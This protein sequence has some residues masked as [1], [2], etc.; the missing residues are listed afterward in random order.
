[1]PRGSSADAQQL[2]RGDQKGDNCE[3]LALINQSATANDAETVNV[4]SGGVDTENWVASLRSRIRSRVL[5]LFRGSPGI[6]AAGSLAGLFATAYLL[7]APMGRDLAAQVAHAQLAEQHWPAV[8]NL[9]WYSGFDPL[10]YS[11]LSPP[12]M[13]LLG[14]RLTTAL[15]YVASVVLF[16][17]LLKGTAVARP[18]AGAIVGAVCLTGNLVTTRTTFALGLAVGLS[19]LVAVVWGRLSVASGLSVL[20]ALTSPVAGLFLG[21]AGGALFLSGRRRGGVTLGLSASLPTIA[22]ALAFGNVGRQPFAEGEA[23]MG[24]LVCLAVAGLCWRR[25]VV[26]WAA[27]L[28]AGLVGASYLLPIPVGTT[29]TR[30]PEL[31]AAPTIVAVA[32]VPL[33]AVIAA[34]ASVVLLLPPMSIT[35]VRERGDPAL[36]AKYYAPL[37]DQLVARGVAGPIEVVPTLRRGEAAVVA[38]VVPIARGWSRQVDTGRNPIFFDGTLNADTYRSWL[39]DNAISYVAISNGPHEWAAT[40]EATLV[41]RGLP[42]LQ[43]VWSDRTWTL[44]AV[45]NPRPVISPPGQVIARDGVS[46]TVSLPEPGEYLVRVHWS[47]YLSASNGCVRPAE[48]GWSMVVVDHP[49]TVKIEGSLRPRHC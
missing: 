19:A 40:D 49:D 38:P 16:A 28:S 10:G 30:L 12:V 15:A 47:R 3:E 36:S 35:E 8:L 4:N 9:R 33:V 26:R 48:D 21:V 7:A 29:A 23:L 44:Y 18:V 39:D 17:A 2:R 25:P 20:A 31:F 13:A 5:S 34:T 32:T 46:L 1:L 41:R 45:T 37:L 24:F 27:L 42:Y 22:V 43:A 6:V 14:V 11:V